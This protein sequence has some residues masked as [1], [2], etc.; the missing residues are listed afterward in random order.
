[1]MFMKRMKQIKSPR[2]LAL[3]QC[4]GEWDVFSL[5][6]CTVLGI[7]RYIYI[8]IGQDNKYWRLE[9][10]MQVC[11]SSQTV[12]CVWQSLC[13][14]YLIMGATTAAAKTDWALNQH[15]C[16]FMTIMLIHITLE[17]MCICYTTSPFCRLSTS[18]KKIIQGRANLSP[19]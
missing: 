6:G 13:V 3:L 15:T 12:L 5:L 8:Y 11:L 2:S 18:R 9:K 7:F 4:L 19:T 10:N 17:L 1:M 14:M 16:I